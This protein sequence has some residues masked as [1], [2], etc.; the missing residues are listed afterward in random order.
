MKY[1]IV[2]ARHEICCSSSCR[3]RSTYS[4]S[5]LTSSRAAPGSVDIDDR[6]VRRPHAAGA[7]V[8]TSRWP[9]DS[10]HSTVAIGMLSAIKRRVVVHYDLLLAI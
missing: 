3:R 1:E 6:V 9:L 5:R 7:L 8:A 4:P 10:S 2:E